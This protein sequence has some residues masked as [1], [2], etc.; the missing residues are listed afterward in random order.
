MENFNRYFSWIQQNNE[1]KFSI[2]DFSSSPPHAII[3]EYRRGTKLNFISWRWKLDGKNIFFFFLSKAISIF[4]K[5]NL[6]LVLCFDSFWFHF[7]VKAEVFIE[8]MRI[9]YERGEAVQDFEKLDLW[10]I[11]NMISIGFYSWANFLL[12]L[13]AQFVD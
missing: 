1:H 3:F 10:L 12:F 13:L 6:K 11:L 8:Y 2:T 9:Y 4:I 7:E 5:F